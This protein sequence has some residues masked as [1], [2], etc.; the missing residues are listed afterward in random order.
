MTGKTISHYKILE[1][2]GGMTFIWVVVRNTG[3]WIMILRERHK[4][5]TIKAERNSMVESPVNYCSWRFIYIYIK[6]LDFQ[7]NKIYGENS[8]DN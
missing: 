5:R 6:I 3:S 2:I 7:V 4:M 1:K 8:C